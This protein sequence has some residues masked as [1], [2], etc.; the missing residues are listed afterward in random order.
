MPPER[1]DDA[2]TPGSIHRWPRWVYGSGSEPDARF[3]FANE[4]TFLAWIR[5]GLA[6]LTA[7]VGV[8]ALHNYFP[9]L[10]EAQIISLVLV[11]VGVL[12]G[13][14]AFFRWMAQEKAMRHNR[15]LRSSLMMPVLSVALAVL[16]V[17]A[18]VA[19]V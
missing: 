15:P 19:L 6:F 5:T 2:P 10:V 8:A 3:S 12:S 13:V 7:G 11:G 1:P 18:L 16:A 4:R 17:F 9:G 14:V